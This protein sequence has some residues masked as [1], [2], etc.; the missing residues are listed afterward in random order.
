MD[1]RARGA[2]QPMHAVRKLERMHGQRIGHA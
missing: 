2:S 1:P